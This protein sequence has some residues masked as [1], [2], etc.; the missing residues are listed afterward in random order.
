MKILDEE[1]MERIKALLKT[2]PRGLSISNIASITRLNRNLIAKYLDMLVISGHVEVQDYGPA[3]VYYFSQRIPVTAMIDITSD[4]VMVLDQD[5][6]IVHVNKP[7]TRFLALPKEEL[8]GKNIAEAGHPFLSIV[9]LPDPSEPADQEDRGITEVPYSGEGGEYLFRIKR[10]PAVFEDGSLGLTLIIENITAQRQYE[11]Q[12]RLSEAR[13]RGI[14]EDQ[15][16]FITRF[17]PDTTVT[18]V[19]E[20]FARYMGQSPEGLA[21]KPF[22]DLLPGEERERML[23]SIRSLT[24]Q[25]PTA[26]QEHRMQ[27]GRGQP[28]WVHWTTRALFDENGTVQEYQGIGR[29]ITEQREATAK[30]SQYILQLEFI[31]RKSLEF[32]QTTP[33]ED[34]HLI[35]AR[36]VKSLYPESVVWVHSYEKKADCMKVETVLDENART[37]IRET[38]G[39][40]PVGVLCTIT[41]ELAKVAMDGVLHKVP[42][43]TCAAGFRDT[44]TG[45]PIAGLADIPG[46][47]DIYLMGLT[48]LEELFGLVILVFRERTVLE[49]QHLLE[50][51][52]NQASIAVQRQIFF[53]QLGRTQAQYCRIVETSDE[54]IWALDRDFRTSFVNRRLAEMLG[55]MPREMWGRRIDEFMAEEDLPAQRQ[56]EEERRTGQSGRF[57]QRFRRKDGSLIWTAASATPIMEDGEFGGAFAMVTDITE[58]KKAEDR[59]KE[60]EALQEAI[61]KA[62]P[63]AIG[64]VT[65]RTLTWANDAMYRLQENEPGTWKG[66]PEDIGWDDKDEFARIARTLYGGI[67]QQ[68][69]G[70]VET[71]WK[72]K[73]GS[74]AHISFRLAPLHPGSLDQVVVVATD[75]TGERRAERQL[76]ESED[77]RKVILDASPAGIGLVR[78][79]SFVWANDAMARLLSLRP[80]DLAGMPERLL[81][82]DDG[83][84]GRVSRALSEGRERQ[85]SGPVETVLKR[86]D[87]SLLGISLRAVPVSPGSPDIIIVAT[88]ITGQEKPKGMWDR[89]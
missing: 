66:K 20:G 23:E 28:R 53:E 68:G 65:N 7:F 30:I 81:F 2:H 45:K 59:L 50:T 35:I 3:K 74:P 89:Q 80:E 44:T 46:T 41:P 17:L 27:D 42:A 36:G 21:G 29:D 33:G 67:E 85:G 88:D 10:S 86:S 79:H 82:T 15:A 57:E 24:P 19:N 5:R 11:E 62:T 58:R 54:G 48:Y 4:L 64:F 63:V 18:F 76:K 8:L 73:D 37:R 56:R 40:D 39:R 22:V 52:L 78:N 51:Y 69:L 6:K 32:V 43:D 9:P 25:K 77:L 87:G 55:Y 26:S 60:T 61:L 47:P 12:L 75:I 49:H 84:Y 34:I 14:V 71:V 13:Y 38:T 83:E 72:R 1:K 70:E 16:D 31:S